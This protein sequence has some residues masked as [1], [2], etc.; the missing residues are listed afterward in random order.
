MPVYCGWLTAARLVSSL[1]LSN[2]PI[3]ASPSIGVLAKVAAGLTRD[4]RCP[5]CG[6]VFVL[7]WPSRSSRIWLQAGAL[8]GGLV[9]SF[10]WLT[11]V[12]FGLG[13]VVMLLAPIFLDVAARTTDPLTAR[14]L[15]ARQ[16]R[17]R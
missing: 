15:D 13:L 11:P 3:C 6:G 4:V 5:R 12:P 1:I 10:L 2:C 16:K 8:G 7:R 17:R 14:Q 9:L